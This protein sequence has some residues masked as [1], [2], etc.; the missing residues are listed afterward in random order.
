MVR[1]YV[2][3]FFF[4]G[5]SGELYLAHVYKTNLHFDIDVCNLENIQIGEVNLDISSE[6]LYFILM[7][8]YTKR[9]EMII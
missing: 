5:K 6:E 7:Y 1:K 4:E 9:K 8:M 2:K 3:T